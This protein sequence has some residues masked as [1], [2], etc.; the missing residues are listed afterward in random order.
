V[1]SRVVGYLYDATTNP[2]VNGSVVT[3]R[4]GAAPAVVV[5]VMMMTAACSSAYVN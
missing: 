5:V 1:R 3:L 2:F 4:L